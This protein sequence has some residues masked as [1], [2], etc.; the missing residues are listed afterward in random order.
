MTRRGPLSATTL[1]TLRG[2]FTEQRHN[3]SPDHW[4]AIGDVANAME[5]MANGI[6]PLK[7]MLSSLDCGVGKTQ[8]TLAFARAL[9]TS[10]DHRDVGMLICVGRLTEAEAIAR[11][12]AIPAGRLAVLTSDRELNS[13][14]PTAPAS[15]QVL[16]TTQQRMERTIDGQT[17]AGAE[18]FFFEGRPRQVRVWDE[19]WLPG[20]TVSVIRDD[21]YS[22]TKLVRPLSDD[23]AEALI[24]L[25]DSLKG[26]S[27]GDAVEVPDFEAL[28][29]VSLYEVLAQAAG[30]TGRFRDDQQLT[31]T[32]LAA[33]NGKTARVRRDG[34]AG[35]V[36]LTYRETFPDD[37]MPLLVLDASGRVR[38]TYADMEQHRGNLL[39]LR[40]AVKDYSPL[41]VRTWQTG[42]GKSGFAQQGDVLAKG[43]ADTILTKPNE[44][45][46][47]VAHKAGG[48]VKNV[49]TAIRRHLQ[50]HPVG[51]LQVITWGNHMATNA[52]AGVPNV[53]LAGTLF[54]RPSCYTALTNLAQGQP[55]ARGLAS[56]ADVAETMRGEHR[57]L[58]YQALCRGRVRKSDGDKCQPMTAYVIASKRSGIP[59]D[60]Q[61]IFPGCTVENWNPTKGVLK[62]VAKRAFTVVQTAIKRGEAWLSFAAIALAL[63]MDRKNFKSRIQRDAVWLQAV[64]GLGARPATGPRKASGLA[65]SAEC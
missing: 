50:G 52:F 17:F 31:A 53:I 61:T 59:R 45:W 38:Q 46:L 4:E 16:V 37:F 24:C 15:A 48:A 9:V 39:R 35:N 10:P 23:L 54:M 58:V 20:V 3:P 7:V 2:Y 13:I 49:E 18:A 28:Y 62:G 30:E 64:A 14:T 57:H 21:L 29:G 22:L 44:G 36:I 60:L 42:G 55:V 11:T 56:P 43:I 34:K 26:L 1:G 65:L 5:S 12:L 47:V 63:K 8:T 33:L 27:D 6:A 19:A 40:S 41:T 51:N 32:A 25:A